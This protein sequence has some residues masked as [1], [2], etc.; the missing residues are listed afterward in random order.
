M[1]TKNKNLLEVYNLKKHFPVK[2]GIFRKTVGHVKAVDGISFSIERGK[3]FGLV[4]ESGCGKTT[5]GRTLIALYQPTD[6]E[7][8]FDVDP[9]TIARMRE[10]EEQVK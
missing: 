7:M 8:F 2:A 5:A 9:E 6:G 3:T 4:G 10:L 1:S